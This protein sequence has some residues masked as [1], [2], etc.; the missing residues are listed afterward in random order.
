MCITESPCSAEKCHTV[1]QSATTLLYSVRPRRL[2]QPCKSTIVIE[3]LSHV[4][5]LCHTMQW[6]QPGPL[7]MGFPRQEYWSEW[8]FPSP[9]DL[10][11]PGIQPASPALAGK[12]G[13]LPLSHLGSPNQLWKW[14]SKSLSPARLFAT[15]RTLQLVE[16]SRPEYWSG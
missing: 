13:A 6:G 3:S 8:P 5:L 2:A 9:G 14:K 12:A 16:F 11:D 1:L 15:C 7:S 4:R 10:P